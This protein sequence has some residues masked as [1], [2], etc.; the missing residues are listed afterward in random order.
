[1]PLLRESFCPEGMVAELR[2][3][4]REILGKLQAGLVEQDRLREEYEH[5]RRDRIAAQREV[6]RLGHRV[7][8]TFEFTIHF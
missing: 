6:E 4:S 3:S 7:V 2:E 1:M 5:A 8:W